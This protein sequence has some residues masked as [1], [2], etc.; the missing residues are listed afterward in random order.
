MVRPAT[1][2]DGVGGNGSTSWRGRVGNFMGV[3][4]PGRSGR[5]LRTVVQ[6]GRWRRGAAPPGSGPG[7]EDGGPTG[8]P[9]MW[10]VD[11]ARRRP[12]VDAD[13]ERASPGRNE[14]CA[15]P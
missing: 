3:V 2:A 11:A 12:R 4:A 1:D 10:R 7:R 13:V 14:P 9:G 6:D 15:R 5:H 8:R